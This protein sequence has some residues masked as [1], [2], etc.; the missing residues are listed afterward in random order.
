MLHFVGSGLE[1]LHFIC[2]NEDNDEFKKSEE[3]QWKG[4]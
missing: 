4:I 1:K 3:E 2:F